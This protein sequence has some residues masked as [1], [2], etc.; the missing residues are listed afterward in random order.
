MA[1]DISRSSF[2]PLKHNSGVRKQQGRVDLDADWN[3]QVDIA[4]YFSRMATL[5]LIGPSGAPASNPG[6]EISVESGNLT[7]GP[8]RM[9][10]DGILCENAQTVMIVAAPAPAVVPPPAHNQ[11]G[12]GIVR[13]PFIPKA[14]AIPKALPQAALALPTQPDLP[15]YVLPTLP[16]NYLVYLD[17]W[18]REITGL[19]DPSILEI[20]L[21]GV[22]TATRT[23]IVWQV[24]LFPSQAGCSPNWGAFLPPST[25]TMIAQAQP[26]AGRI[27][28]MRRTGPG[29]L[30]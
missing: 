8:G 9:Y 12:M 5:D 16:G 21:A 27:D 13:K 10:V 20:A 19:E 24:K 26:D 25:G 1:G 22:D 28:S 2:Q 7:V 30:Q 4:T 23:R 29:R 18:E 14:A 11:P 15:G 3:E 6:F 17:V